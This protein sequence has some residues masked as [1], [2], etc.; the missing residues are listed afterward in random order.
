M[1]KVDQLPEAVNLVP[2]G[3]AEGVGRTLS[4]SDEQFTWTDMTAKPTT[5]LDRPVRASRQRSPSD[6][7]AISNDYGANRRYSQTATKA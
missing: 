5:S 3:P 2:I 6:P 4:T 1:P 7:R